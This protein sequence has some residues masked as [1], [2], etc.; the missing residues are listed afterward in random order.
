MDRYRLHDEERRRMMERPHVW[1]EG[2]PEEEASDAGAGAP[3]DADASI[4][5][6]PPGVLR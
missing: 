3:D 5:R 2:V 6:V 1:V 4:L